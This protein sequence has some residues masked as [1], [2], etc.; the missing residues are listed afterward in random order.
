MT[1]AALGTKESQ[2]FTDWLEWQLVGTGTHCLS[3]EL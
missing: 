2:A 3:E 1:C